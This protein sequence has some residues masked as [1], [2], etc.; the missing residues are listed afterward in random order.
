MTRN[1]FEIPDGPQPGAPQYKTFDQGLLPMLEQTKRD[2][3]DDYS[4]FDTYISGYIA[5]LNQFEV[6]EDRQLD[7][8]AA[9]A[10]VIDALNAWQEQYNK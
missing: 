10:I 1:K 7:G 6:I 3:G 2:L 4:S 9:A 5:A 8:D